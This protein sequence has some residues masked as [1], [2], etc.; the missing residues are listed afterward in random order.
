MNSLQS[1]EK[2]K[3]NTCKATNIVSFII[4]IIFITHMIFVGKCLLNQC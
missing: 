3:H 2:F 4:T 1:K